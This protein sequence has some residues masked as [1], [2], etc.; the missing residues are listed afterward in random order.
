VTTST[1]SPKSGAQVTLILTV[2]PDNGDPILASNVGNISPNGG[3]TD[4]YGKLSFVFT[5]PVAGGLH[6]IDAFCTGCS[7]WAEGKI[8][9]PG[10]PEPPL[11]V[12]T[13]P[14][15]IDF[16]NGNRWRPD[17][18]TGD[19]PAHLT[20][21]ENAITAAHGTY[22][23]TSAYRPT[24]YQRHL[25][26]I[27]KKDVKLD[28]DYM[29]AHPECQALRD[30]VTGEMGPSPGHD[31]SYDQPVARPGRSR[32]E[33]GTAFDLTPY[34]LTDAQLAPIDPNCG[35]SHTAVIGEPWHT[36]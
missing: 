20:C 32:H 26:E 6:T 17:L 8:K 11:T 9:V 29:I 24:Q 23:G 30:E 2:K 27:I 7:N 16:D 28:T 5:A 4:S 21:V 18:L 14:V 22:T 10:C 31:L 34:G 15:A 1:G 25:Y 12:L 19:Y 36:Q 13:D 33:T 3:A 35:V